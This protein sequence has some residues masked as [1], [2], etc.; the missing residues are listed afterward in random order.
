MIRKSNIVTLHVVGMIIL[1][2]KSQFCFNIIVHLFSSIFYYCSLHIGFICPCV[3]IN[4][5][6]KVEATEKS[7]VLIQGH[8]NV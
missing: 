1:H 3:Y 4:M 7:I 5:K 2:T 6:K 8:D